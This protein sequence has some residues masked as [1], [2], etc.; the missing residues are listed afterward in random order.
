MGPGVVLDKYSLSKTVACIHQIDVRN[1]AN[2][3]PLNN[4]ILD[5]SFKADNN[6]SI[7]QNKFD[8][9]YYN[10]AFAVFKLELYSYKIKQILQF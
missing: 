4:L 10:L 2:V 3:F 8:Y 9:I 5:S 7:Q 6:F 1:M